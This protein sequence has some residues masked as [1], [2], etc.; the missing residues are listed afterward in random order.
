LPPW[1]LIS[2]A[3]ALAR[4]EF[5]LKRQIKKSEWASSPLHH[6][7]AS[8]NLLLMPCGDDFR[9]AERAAKALVANFSLSGE[10]N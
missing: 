10:L 1:I 8:A 3:G 9:L 7:Q 4:Q 2:P 6:N 5:H